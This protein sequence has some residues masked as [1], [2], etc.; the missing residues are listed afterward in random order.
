MNILILQVMD[1]NVKDYSVYSLPINLEYSIKNDYDYLLYQKS[2]FKHHP[3]WLKLEAFREIDLGKYEYIWVL[4]TD[5]IINNHSIKLESIIAK[6]PKEIIISENGSNGGRL[7]N[8]GS[9]LYKASIIPELL[10]RYTKWESDGSEFMQKKYWEQEMLNDWYE[11]DPSR[12]SVRD[13]NEL[14]SFWD[15]DNLKGDEASILVYHYMGRGDVPKGSVGDRASMMKR[16]FYKKH[17]L[18]IIVNGL[19]GMK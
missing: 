19:P 15:I 14:N 7:M 10:E 13:M 12:F 18:N 17:L 5:C 9:I 16:Y 11:E 3:S 8:A 6:D 2:D 4:D 1:R